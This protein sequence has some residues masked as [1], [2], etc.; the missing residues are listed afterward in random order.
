M[1]VCMVNPLFQDKQILHIFLRETVTVA[2]DERV[3]D[4]ILKV[5]L[6]ENG[7]WQEINWKE[8]YRSFFEYASS[9]WVK[10]FDYHFLNTAL[11]TVKE[12]ETEHLILGSSYPRFGILTERF[13]GR[14]LNL[15]LPSQDFYY[16]VKVAERVVESC[17]VKNILWGCG[18]YSLYSD[19]SRTSI[20]SERTRISKVYYPIFQDMHNALTIAEN[21]GLIS[22]GLFDIEN[23]IKYF[24]RLIYEDGAKDYFY[25]WNT[26]ERLRTT[27]WEDPG[28]SWASLS[29]EERREAA[30]KRAALHNKA[31]K[32]KESCRENFGILQEF[33][34]FCNERNIKFY[35]CVFPGSQEY[36]QSQSPEFKRIL[37]QALNAIEGEIHLIDLNDTEL[38]ECGHFND[39]DHLN[40]E[41][42][43]TASDLVSYVL[44]EDKI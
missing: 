30:G 25:K 38:F 14:T 7:A 29:P 37:F 15:S 41:G 11:D 39:M 3:P 4:G 43:A 12:Q 17:P 21:P 8:T 33:V 23:I 13:A 26:R 18:Y 5:R 36:C 19:L 44:E 1:A 35:F 24:D 2:L 6:K 28:K 31:L 34:Q 16:S 20:S 27:M 10:N 9:L 22:S 42:A 32:N 40:A